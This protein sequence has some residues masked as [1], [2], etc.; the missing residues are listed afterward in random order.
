MAR[1]GGREAVS[2]PPSVERIAEPAGLTRERL[3]DALCRSR[4]G[5]YNSS[6][7]RVVLAAAERL[8]A[9]KPASD[10]EMFQAMR[11][12]NCTLIEAWRQAESRLLPFADDASEGNESSTDWR[13]DGRA[14]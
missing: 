8:L 3:A 7:C 13:E 10:E 1:G 2:T 6:H 5:S 12:G 9:M 4:G 11:A 14:W